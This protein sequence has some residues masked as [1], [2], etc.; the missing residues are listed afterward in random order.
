MPQKVVYYSLDAC[1]G[2]PIL[3]GDNSL[4]EVTKK[5]RIELTNGMFD[6]TGIPTEDEHLQ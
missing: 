6:N 5:G 4:V 3:I 2:P 1:K